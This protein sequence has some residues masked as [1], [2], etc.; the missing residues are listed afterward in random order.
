MGDDLKLGVDQNHYR[1]WTLYIDGIALP[2][3][4]MVG[5]TTGTF[6][7][8]RPELQDI[9]AGWTDGNLYEIM[10]AEDPVSERPGPAVTTPMAPR[11]LRVIPGDSN[12]V[13]NWKQPLKDGNSAI[14]HYR[15]QWKLASANWSD[16]NAVGEDIAPPPSGGYTEGFHMITGLDNYAL[17]TLRVIAVNGMGD[18]QPSGEHFGMPQAQSLHVTDAVVNGNQLTITYERALDGGSVPGKESF[19]VLVNGAPRNVTGVSISGRSV[20]LTLEEPYKRAIRATDVVE[21]RYV[22]P[23]SGSPA[24]RDAWGNYASCCE[25]GEPA[26]W[27][28]NQTDPGLL[29][30]VSAEFTT[31]PEDHSGPGTEVIFQ[32]EFSEPVRVDIGPNF[33]YLLDVEGGMVTS[34][35]WLD[36]DTTTWE[37][38]L[39]PA[40]TGEV[41]I[42]LPAGRACD[43][44]GAPCGSG[45]RRLSNQP[46]HTI[47]GPVSM[48]STSNSP[49]TGGPGIEGTPQTGQTLSATTT[50]IQDQDGMTGAVFAY[51]W[52]RMDLGT[53]IDDEISGAT[54]Q[55]YTVTPDD[56]DQA[57]KVKVSF[58]DD[59][60]NPESLTSYGVFVSPARTRS[61]GSGNNPAT[62]APVIEGSPVVGQTL[63]ANTGGIYD[64]D[65]LTGVSYKYQWISNDGNSDWD[66]KG[67]TGPAYTLVDGDQGKTIR[68]R[69]S[70]ADDAGNKET[71]TSQATAEVQ[72][73]PNSPATGLPTITGTT[74]VGET[75]A[76]DI[77]GIADSDGLT[78][79]S[80]GYQWLADDAAI[81]GATGSTYSV[82]PGDE[83]KSLRV[84]VDFT[85]DGGNSETLTSAATAPVAPRAN[86]P[87]TGAPIIS[88]TPQVGE[89]LT[90]DT[91]GIS[92][93]DGMDRATFSYQWTAAGWDI[94]GATGPSYDLTE[95][96]NGLAVQVK[97]SFNDDAG[98]RESLTSSAVVVSSA[99]T[100]VKKPANS[101][102]T[103]APAIEGSPVVGQT[104]TATT[105][106]IADKD[107]MGKAVF[108]YQWLADDAGIDGATGSSYN[109]VPGDAGKSLSVRV[110]FTDDAGNEESLT[111]Q[112]TAGVQAR[113]N[114]PAT[115][116]PLITGTAR[117]DE[118]LAVD[119][120]GIADTDGMTGAVF[121]YQWTA[122]GSHIAGATG[123]SYALT[124]DEEGLTVQ[125]RVNFNDDAGNSETLTSAGTD[126]VA[127]KAN[128]PATGAPVITGTVQVDQ[129][130]TADTSGI[131]DTDGMD[132]ATFSYQWLAGGSEID[133]ATGSSHDLTKDEEG[134]TV[135]VRVNFNDDAGNQESLTSAAT[136][137]VQPRPNSPATGALI[138]D[139]TPQEGE[140]LRADTSGIADTDGMNN[141]V[142]QYQWLAGESE[143]DGATAST[144]E[145]SG[146]EVGKT[147]Q[148]RAAFED[149]A[150]NRETITSAAT[151]P[152]APKAN[153]PAT[154]APAIS[155]TPQVGETL[156]A[157]TSGISDSDGMD[158]AVFEYQWLA[159]DADIQ[160]ATSSSYT[161]AG[162]DAGKTISVEV[163]FNDDAGNGETLTSPA[164]A[165]VQPQPNS[166]ATGAVV[167]SGTPRVGETLT[168]DTS[169]IADTDGM[170]SAVFQYQWL[171]R[172]SEIAGA[173]GSSYS[174]TENEVGSTVQV[175]VSFNDDAGNEESL[176]SEQTAQV[177]RPPLTVT[178]ENAPAG[179]DGQAD[180]TFEIR[181]S[182]EFPVS[183]ERLRDHAFT[184][185]G[186]QVTKAQRMDKPSNIPW[187]VTVKP[188]G[189]GDVT[190]ALP[191]TTDCQAAGAICTGDGR[192]LSNSLSFTVSGPGG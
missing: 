38:V 133:G 69:V 34:A 43:A 42:T 184:V 134:L 26:S 105:S 192:K 179:H 32:I 156:T 40:S 89:T 87:A 141:A 24:I 65:G 150:G 98:N 79:V 44:P 176:T 41:K 165:E 11:Y 78:G 142:F 170:N 55:T 187:R 82:A 88:G 149:D 120:S 51:Q 173:T 8:H 27:V 74:Q 29:E 13:A 128:S 113:P 186:G 115:G 31:A 45:E 71:L 124:E 166:P 123:S 119:T 177:V 185:T 189:G 56:E 139:G 49:A 12:L 80:Y 152:V 158:N 108:A 64:S 95:N 85:D 132:Q 126:A 191:V 104:L 70:F 100:R 23:P 77:S 162:S 147:I 182:E 175:Q 15:V 107:G 36:R 9:Y 54:G 154:G 106:G 7:W 180:F 76:A 168:A 35:W 111:S 174:L 92:D 146:A 144:Y 110:S 116:A 101:P 163:S 159:G 66:I 18:S 112:A 16:Q 86:S 190:V 94:V 10:I 155:G 97:V 48:N 33:A 14:T 52:I 109:V 25:F 172:G 50:G 6:I 164:T 22:T 90:A 93:S 83:G 4:D 188:D 145:L 183:Y 59:A 138:I 63:T 19:W 171:V 127:P 67:A 137:E 122:G 161:V 160:D 61:T 121:Q 118:T 96:E 30:P 178:L 20:I 75:L 60:G 1:D 28:R 53:A 91:S 62:G 125:V 102:A 148:V 140:T 167:I 2:F 136:A 47:P 84:R 131:S 114:S 5:K 157:D 57:L 99:Q 169:G 103:G 135:Q 117:V 73:R 46:E 21:F 17:Y 151:A 181:F 81:D 3:T 58:T 68:V 37:I 153:S 143:I 129:T 39:E 130:L 72:A